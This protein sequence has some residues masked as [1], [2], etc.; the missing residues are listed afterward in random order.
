[1][2]CLSLCANIKWH[3]AGF[4]QPA[5]KQDIFIFFFANF[6]H[7]GMYKMEKNRS[8]IDMV[9]FTLIE[10]SSTMDIINKHMG[11]SLWIFI[12]CPVIL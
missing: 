9:F 2:S 3:H 6:P 4:S 5:G 8:F 7:M 1:M 12:L 11:Y 10:K